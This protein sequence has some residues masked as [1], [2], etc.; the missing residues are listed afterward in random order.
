MARRCGT[1]PTRRSASSA[2]C[3]T[4]AGAGL[5]PGPKDSVALTASVKRG[6]SPSDDCTSTS[7]AKCSIES[8][9]ASSLGLPASFSGSVELLSRIQWPKEARARVVL[10]NTMAIYTLAERCKMAG[11]SDDEACR[12]ETR[13]LLDHS[14]PSVSN[15]TA[16]WPEY[17]AL[18]RGARGAGG[19]MSVATAAPSSDT[20][21]DAR[22]R[23][24]PAVDA[25]GGARSD[26]RDRAESSS[27]R[28]AH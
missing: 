5:R 26:A 6:S 4:G 28:V 27:H 2:G 16:A 10:A 23:P 13:P 11:A 19:P 22:E 14:R 18:R 8:R 7:S 3:L 24:P 25:L 20:A 21:D 15:L 9:S 12:L 17:A 1:R